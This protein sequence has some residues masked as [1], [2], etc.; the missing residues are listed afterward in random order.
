VPPFAT[1][2][3]ERGLANL[4]KDGLISAR[5]NP[6]TGARLTTRRKQG[7]TLLTVATRRSEAPPVAVGLPQ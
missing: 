3:I 2:T 6:I 5:R 1:K 7:R 4:V